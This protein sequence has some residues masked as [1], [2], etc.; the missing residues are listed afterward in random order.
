MHTLISIPFSHYNE[1]AKWALKYFGQEYK[2]SGYLPF[3]HMLPVWFHTRGSGQNKTDRASTKFSTPVLK[4]Y[5]GKIFCDSSD[6]VFYLSK[7]Y[8]TAKN[9][10]YWSDEIKRKEKYFDDMFGPH[11][12]KLAY[13]YLFENL[14]LLNELVDANFSGLQK[15]SFKII[16]PFMIKRMKRLL[17]INRKSLEKSLGYIEKEVSAVEATLKTQPFI[18]GDKFSAADL[19]FCALAAPLIWLSQN[20]GY[21]AELPQRNKAP[22]ELAQIINEYR[23]RPAGEFIVRIFKNY[24]LNIS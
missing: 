20:E 8:G 14:H 5:D 13:Y 1:K 21:T 3:Y 17:R 6:I 24:K 2:E 4:T 18:C 15:T 19:S 12:R 9:D 11:T 7:T 10:L 22:E 16:E 23:A